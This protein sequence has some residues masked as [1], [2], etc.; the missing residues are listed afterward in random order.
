MAEFVQI[1]VK[2]QAEKV[3]QKDELVDFSEA[4]PISNIIGKI[5]KDGKI[6]RDWCLPSDV[7]ESL[8]QPGDYC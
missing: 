3:N 7:F 1:A 4:I 8:E 2:N 5:S 6:T